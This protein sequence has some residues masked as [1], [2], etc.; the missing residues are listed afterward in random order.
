METNTQATQLLDTEELKAAILFV[1]REDIADAEKQETYNKIYI[2]LERYVIS[3]MRSVFPTY[4][5]K[6]FDDMKQE[7]FMAIHSVILR[8]QPDK[9]AVTTW[10]KPHIIHALSGF[11]SKEQN[12]TPYYSS[13]NKK[14]IDA[15]NEL[16]KMG[17]KYTYQDISEKSGLPLKTIMRCKQDMQQVASLDTFEDNI[18]G[19]LSISPEDEYIKNEEKEALYRAM[20]SLSEE[21]KQILEMRFGIMT[22]TPIPPSKIAEKLG[23]P[24]EVVTRNLVTGKRKLNNILNKNEVFSERRLKKEI[25]TY[26]MLLSYI[27]KDE[28]I[29]KE[30]IQMFI[31][32]IDCTIAGETEV[33]KSDIM[34][35]FL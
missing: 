19:E 34:K 5:Q 7:A 25:D 17:V 8:Y 4:W 20:K 14:I 9:G 18:E 11:I 6:N 32:S 10:I 31:D 27:P 21:Q 28:V 12:S 16:I 29:E 23:M 35:I 2:S 13:A 15:E 33:T 26:K 1:Q 30:E 24:K 3:I 22:G